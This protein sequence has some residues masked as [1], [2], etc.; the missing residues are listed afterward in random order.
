MQMRADALRLASAVADANISAHPAPVTTSAAPGAAAKSLTPKYSPAHCAA[1]AAVDGGLGAAPCG[2]RRIAQKLCATVETVRQFLATHYLL[3]T[4]MAMHHL[5]EDDAATARRLASACTTSCMQ[6]WAAGIHDDVAQHIHS[7]LAQ[8]ELAL[9]EAS[10]RGNARGSGQGL[11]SLLSQA[12]VAT[13]GFTAAGFADLL[14]AVYA[15]QD[16]RSE[17]FVSVID[18]STPGVEPVALGSGVDDLLMGASSPQL[19]PAGPRGVLHPISNATGDLIE[20][21]LLSALGI[22]GT[23]LVPGATAAPPQHLQGSSC[24]ESSV[25][26]EATVPMAAQWNAGVLE[27]GAADPFWQGQDTEKLLALAQRCNSTACA[28]PH[29]APCLYFT[30]TPENESL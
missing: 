10:A 15:P 28:L 18:R 11:Q 8:H 1:D 24:S 2:A 4:E 26:P 29:C 20:G 9:V 21:R 13:S 19:L 17:G 14:S 12:T 3:A 5:S 23:S 16:P 25:T 7:M 27:G 22:R 6:I 30:T